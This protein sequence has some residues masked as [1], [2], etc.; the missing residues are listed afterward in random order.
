MKMDPKLYFKILEVFKR[1]SVASDYSYF[2]QN[3]LLAELPSALKNEILVCTHKKILETFAFFKNKPLS[4]VMDLLP[5]LTKITLSDNDILYRKKDLVEESNLLYIYI[6]I[7]YFLIKGRVGFTTP[8]GYLFR[9]FACG[10]YFGE[11]ELF[12]SKV[13]REET[14][15]VMEDTQLLILKKQDLEN[16][17]LL[18]PDIAQE[19]AIVAHQRNEKNK[20]AVNIAEKTGYKLDA[21]KYI[22]LLYIHIRMALL[23]VGTTDFKFHEFFQEVQIYYSYI[24][25]FRKNPLIVR[26]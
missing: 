6:Y 14:A 2:D 22:Y 21:Q 23:K 18:Y 16:A 8:E 20:L 15:I 10:S 19:M 12:K 13:F 3:D 4:F 1:N 9:N 26:A 24:Y 25:L 11:I 7:V 5:K 17:L